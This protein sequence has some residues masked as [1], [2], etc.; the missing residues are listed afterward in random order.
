MMTLKIAGVSHANPDGSSRQTLVAALTV[1]DALHLERDPDNPFDSNAVKVCD[2]AGRQLGF[3]PKEQA[4]G[5]SARLARGELL[6]ARVITLVG[7][8]DRLHGCRFTVGEVA[9]C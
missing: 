3:V 5:L 8:R 9:S 6:V 2:T 1:G 7:G 4:A